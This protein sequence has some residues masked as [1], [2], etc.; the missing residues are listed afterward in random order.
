MGDVVGGW[1]ADTICEY[2][3]PIK[4][5]NKV[6]EQ[7]MRIKYANKICEQNM[8]TKHANNKKTSFDTVSCLD[9]LRLLKNRICE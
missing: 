4:Y 6:C 5:A 9:V 1:S 8:R 7:N 2:T 3:M